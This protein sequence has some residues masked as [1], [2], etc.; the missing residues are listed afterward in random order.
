MAP[1]YCRDSENELLQLFVLC[2]LL[3]ITDQQLRLGR[4]SW[5]CGLAF[6]WGRRTVTVL[7]PFLTLFKYQ[8]LYVHVCAQV[9]MRF[10][11]RQWRTKCHQ[12][13]RVEEEDSV[14]SSVSR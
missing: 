10:R 14:S 12:V 8:Y 7:V 11:I 4:Q 6:P 2:H 9:C 5:A 13:P 3:E 1:V